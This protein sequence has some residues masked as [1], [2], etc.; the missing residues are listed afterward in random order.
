MRFGWVQVTIASQLGGLNNNQPVWQGYIFT[1]ALWLE[2]DN[3][4]LE[5]IEIK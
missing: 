1:W 4:A 5:L 3:A 2:Y